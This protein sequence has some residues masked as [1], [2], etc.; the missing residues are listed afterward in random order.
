MAW[1]KRLGVGLVGAGNFARQQHIPNLVRMPEADL[2]ALCDV[3]EA[4]LHSV[5]EDFG[6]RHRLTDFDELLNLEN[7]DLI[8]LTVRDDLQPSMATRALEAGKD[9]Y[10]EKP[11]S[12]SPEECE[13]VARAS[14]RTGRRLAVGFNKRFAP[15]YQKARE[16]IERHGVP[17]SLHFA[18]T[19][20][21]WRWA[22]GYP[23]GYLMTLDVCHHIDLV[24]YL[25]N[26]RIVSVYCRSSRPE[27]DLILLTTDSGAVS[28]IMFSGN[29]SMDTPKEY[30]RL[31]GDRWSLTGEDFV[32]LY[33][34]GLPDCP[35]SYRFP[36]HIQG[37]RPFLH[38]RLMEKQGIA[39]WRNI[40][41]IAWELQREEAPDESDEAEEP[42]FIPNFVRD[43]GWFESLRSFVRAIVSGEET[44]HAGAQDAAS[45]ARVTSAAVES[46][47]SGQVVSVGG[48]SG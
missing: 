9:V 21:A 42:R 26:S 32:E 29:D 7:I 8:V 2:R 23:P 17:A 16:V 40:R 27:D 12:A 5:A 35:Q 41:R 45:I 1:D 31:I 34:H 25:T 18:M 14:S 37:S 15:M 11:L 47:S 30:A 38:R 24:Q 20:D 28:S 46:R 39:G 19:D 13:K 48:N 36:G 3:D 10:V 44:A 33:V 22:R 43:Q 6:V 4:Q